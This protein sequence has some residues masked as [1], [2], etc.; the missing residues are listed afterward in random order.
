MSYHVHPAL[1]NVSVV[2]ASAGPWHNDTS[3]RAISPFEPGHIIAQPLE[4]IFSIPK[5][6][7]RLGSTFPRPLRNV[8][9]LNPSISAINKTTLYP[10]N[11]TLAASDYGALKTKNTTAKIGFYPADRSKSSKYKT[12][13]MVRIMTTVVTVYTA[14]SASLRKDIGS[15]G[16][17]ENVVSTRPAGSAV[18]PG[19][20]RG[21]SEGDI[22]R[23]RLACP[24]PYRSGPGVSHNSN[25]TVEH[26][27]SPASSGHDLAD[28]TIRSITCTGITRNFSMDTVLDMACHI[29]LLP[30]ILNGTSP[31]HNS[32]NSSIPTGTNPPG[33]PAESPKASGTMMKRIDEATAIMYHVSKSIYYTIDSVV[34]LRTAYETHRQCFHNAAMFLQEH[35]ARF[36]QAVDR[37]GGAAMA[38]RAAYRRM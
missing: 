32:T 26:G 11:S 2:T 34:A 30:G 21:S 8:T 12:Q 22:I 38:I 7:S 31:F 35:L 18:S 14:Q 5:I 20:P 17:N 3:S 6:S 29:G 4:T 1:S 16:N 33:V 13:G 28:R 15:G 24:T 37:Y 25:E 19:T 27:T 10:S 36:T 9:A 23:T